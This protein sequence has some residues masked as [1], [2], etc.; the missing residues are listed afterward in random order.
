MVK[1]DYLVY[2]Q[3]K[4]KTQDHLSNSENKP[5]SPPSSNNYQ[6]QERG[7]GLFLHFYKYLSNF[8]LYDFWTTPSP[9]YQF[10]TMCMH[11]ISKTWIKMV[12]WTQRSAQ[13]VSYSGRGARFPSP[14]LPQRSAQK[15]SYPNLNLK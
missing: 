7:G 6:S 4:L 11:L 5:I 8:L 3:S 1:I 15:V 2:A 9:S 12:M 10:C 13:K 14:S